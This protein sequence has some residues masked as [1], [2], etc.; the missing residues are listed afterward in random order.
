M[1]LKETSSYSQHH[2]EET[3]YVTT[4]CTD[5]RL[6]TYSYILVHMYVHTYVYTSTYT[7]YSKY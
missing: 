6:R 2:Q 7:L 5:Y 3:K 4:I 1:R